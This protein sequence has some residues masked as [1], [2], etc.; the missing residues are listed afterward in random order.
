MALRLGEALVREGL[1]TNQQ[2]ARALERQVTYGGRLGTNLVELGILTEESLVKFMGKVFGVPYADP[3]AF[4]A[5]K[6]E[7]IESINPTIAEKY[8]V[9]PIDREPK[10]LHLAMANPTDLRVIDEV[11][12][13]TGY[14]IVPYIASELRLFHALER[15]YGIRRPVRF[16]SVISEAREEVPEVVTTKGLGAPPELKKTEAGAEAVPVT[17]SIR[18]RLVE[19]KDREEIASILLDFASADLKRV[20]L[21]VVKSNAIV[22]WKGMGNHLTDEMMAQIELPLH[23]PSIFRA[24]IDGKDFYQ[25]TMLP[26]PQNMHLLEMM[27]GEVPQEAIAFPLTIKGKVV[28]LL[29]G[30]NGDRSLLS[31][32][33]EE[34]KKAMVKAS[35]ALEM[36]IL[37][38][39]ILEM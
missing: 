33:F 21:F 8:M 20:A 7:V 13:I 37:K 24:V 14:E 18:Q 31:G 5:I 28:C 4:E 10:R 6:R 26:V 35:M 25:G 9:I 15:Y 3:R 23:Q 39:K 27:G 38:K 2:L 1:I 19:A 11:R 36:L 16:I 32:D 34:L 12:F 22:G 17:E 29:Y 30:D